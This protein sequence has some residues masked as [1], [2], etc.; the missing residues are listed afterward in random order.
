MIN[1]IA[2]C[3]QASVTGVAL[4]ETYAST[5]W[6][7]ASIPVAAVSAFGIFNI[8]FASLTAIIGVIFLS[9]KAIFT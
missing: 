2:F 1:S 9:T 3:A 8:K 5:A 7:N 6:V 4:V